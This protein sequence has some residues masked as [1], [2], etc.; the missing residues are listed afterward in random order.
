MSRST[1]TPWPPA[2]RSRWTSSALNVDLLSL[3]AHQ[4]YGPKG[5]A[6]L[7]VRRGVRIAP[8]IDGG[9]QENGRRAGTENVAGIVG[10]GVAARI[11]GEEMP[12]RMAAAHAP[13]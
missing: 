10:M 12:E 2:A 4:F 9:I 11:A 1:P 13:A 6:A 5:A 3:S 7:Y 8:F